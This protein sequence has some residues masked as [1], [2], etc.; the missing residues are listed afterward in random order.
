MGKV[1][2]ATEWGVEPEGM[3]QNVACKKTEGRSLTGS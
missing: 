1:S 2:V 3:E